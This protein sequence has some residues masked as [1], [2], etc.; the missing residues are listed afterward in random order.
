MGWI[1]AKLSPE[2]VEE[3]ITSL[4]KGVLLQVFHAKRPNSRLTGQDQ[5]DAER[6]I[7]KGI[8]PHQ[9]TGRLEK[10]DTNQEGEFYFV[11]KGVCERN[12]KF[13]AFNPSKGFIMKIHQ[14][15]RSIR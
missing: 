11:L 5:R 8:S 1:I 4:E 6:A 7:E 9:Y 14:L 12:G 3:Y 15:G 13:R 10:W 2:E